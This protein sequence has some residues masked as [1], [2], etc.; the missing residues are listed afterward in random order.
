[1][2]PSRNQTST[3]VAARKLVSVSIAAQTLGKSKSAVYRMIRRNRIPHVRE[4]RRIFVE[5]AAL[6]SMIA[7]TPTEPAHGVGE[8]QEPVPIAG[9]PPER[10]ASASEPLQPPAVPRSGHGQ[11]ELTPPGPRA[12]FVVIFW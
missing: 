5:A 2:E 7:I 3:S 12:P 10:A 8:R 4:G 1:M 6:Q 9:K 11:R